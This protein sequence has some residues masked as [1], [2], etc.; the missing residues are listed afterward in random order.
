MLLLACGTAQA[1]QWI[2]LGTP[3]AGPRGIYVDAST[4]HV[5][6]EIRR[7]WF[8]IVVVPGTLRGHG[9]DAGKWTSHVVML[10]EF[11]CREEMSRTETATFYFDDGTSA[12]TDSYTTQWGPVA[13]D[14]VVSAEMKFV[15]TWKPN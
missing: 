7:A 2:L 5:D 1:A 4:V 9:D 8:K 6:G 12:S 15:C 10:D 14:T 11:N 13:P 3:S